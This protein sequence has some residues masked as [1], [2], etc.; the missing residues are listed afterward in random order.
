MQISPS[1]GIIKA[2]GEYKLLRNPDFHFATS[3]FKVTSAC[4]AFIIT[5][6]GSN[7]NHRSVELPLNH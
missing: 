2:F 3:F 4:P 6:E 7:I 5:G 1:D